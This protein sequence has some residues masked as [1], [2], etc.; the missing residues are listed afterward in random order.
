MEKEELTGIMKGCVADSRYRAA[1]VCLFGV[2]SCFLGVIEV[3]KS[4]GLPRKVS[5]FKESGILTFEGGNCAVRCTNKLVQISGREGFRVPSTFP[6]RGNL[7]TSLFELE[8]AIESVG[9]DVV[10]LK[11]NLKALLKHLKNE[12]TAAVLHLRSNHYVVVYSVAG[13]IQLFD[14]LSSN[15]S[16]ELTY[17]LW[18]G[19]VAFCTW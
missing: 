13:V 16:L 5:G 11:T 6:R 17:M 12:D 18:S 19:N 8:R 9:I 4:S 2:C 1:A 7:G 3:G 14:P 10:L 15:A